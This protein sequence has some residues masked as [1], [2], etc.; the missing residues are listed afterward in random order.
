MRYI[1]P[2]VRNSLYWGQEISYQNVGRY[3]RANARGPSDF[4]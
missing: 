4:K 2:F 3:I 1:S